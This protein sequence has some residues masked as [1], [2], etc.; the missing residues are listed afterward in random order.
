MK[1][2]YSLLCKSALLLA[3]AAGFLTG[4]DK[5]SE[6]AAPNKTQVLTGSTWHITAYTRATGSNAP[7]N[8]LNTAFSTACERDDRYAFG[9]NGVQVRTEGP[10]ACAGNTTS[11]VVGTYPWNLNSAQTQ[12]TIG[13]TTFELVQLSASALQLRTT[14]S[15]GGVTVT[16]NVS[17]AD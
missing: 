5:V 8:Y 17:Y 6:T 2:R 1:N 9:T 3:V 14:R 7:V 12:L 13:N 11:T 15:S 10:T 4:C 16:D